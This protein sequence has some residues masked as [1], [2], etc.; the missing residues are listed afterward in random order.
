MFVNIV[1]PPKASETDFTRHS[2]SCVKQS[3]GVTLTNQSQI[4]IYILPIKK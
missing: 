4:I 2:V 3:S 1:L